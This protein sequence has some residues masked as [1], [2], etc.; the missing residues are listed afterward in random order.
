MRILGLHADRHA[1]QA[2]QGDGGV[3]EHLQRV[4]TS[5]RCAGRLRFRQR[6]DVGRAAAVDDLV[7]RLPIDAVGNARDGIVGNRQPHE[8]ASVG[9]LL[10][11][12]YG[13]QALHFPL[14][15]QRALS[16]SVPGRD[17]LMPRMVEGLGER[18]SDG[19]AADEFEFSLK[20]PDQFRNEGS[21]LSSL[22]R[23]A[24][25]S[26]EPYPPALC[27]ALAFS[28]GLVSASF[29]SVISWPAKHVTVFSIAAGDG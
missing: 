6:I 19:A 3:G 11:A 5:D 10:R 20:H 28:A 23:S 7:M 4:E 16:A 22:R 29:R 8:L 15:Q 27:R 9:H 1:R 18:A 24:A 21:S 26:S 2:P 25:H 13:A 12:R 17:D 14:H